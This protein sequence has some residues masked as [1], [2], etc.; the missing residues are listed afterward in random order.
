V[1]VRS[2]SVTNLNKKPRNWSTVRRQLSTW[3]KAAL[4]AL[5]KDLYDTAGVNR[6]FI[7]ARCHAGE[8]SGEGLEIYRSKIVEQFF[9]ARGF[10]KLKLAEARR[11]IR[12]YRKATG[13]VAGVAELL[14]TY[15]E[16]GTKFTQEFGDIDEQFYD[17]IESALTEL[18]A[19][20]RGEARG[21]YPQ[22]SDRLARLE[23]LA[24][25]IGW[26][27]HDF[28]QDVVWHLEEELGRQ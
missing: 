16:N 23:K 1:Q 15:V 22:F 25:G 27:F 6:D 4:F 12:E 20:L 3:D 8:T 26:G 19:L 17:S 14:M 5:I 2:F 9:P 7:H 13:N 18:A 10:G 24:D 11:A 28:V 21:M